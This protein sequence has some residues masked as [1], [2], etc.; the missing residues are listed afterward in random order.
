MLAPSVVEGF[1]VVEN[2]ASG[3]EFRIEDAIL[4]EA[5]G[6]ERGKEALGKGVVV[7]V[8]LGAHALDETVVLQR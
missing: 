5:F 8:S 1:E 2:G 3:L 6:F 7:A 4:R